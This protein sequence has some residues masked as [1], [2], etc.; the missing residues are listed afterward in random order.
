M[1]R[2]DNWH[3][4]LSCMGTRKLCAKLR[5]EGYEVGR[6]LVRQPH[7]YLTAMREMG[8]SSTGSVARS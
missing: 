7:M 3:T 6:K 4:V 5:A 1:A 8:L 2:I